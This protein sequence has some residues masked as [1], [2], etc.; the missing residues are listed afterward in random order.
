MFKYILER[1]GDINWMAISALVTF[2]VLFVIASVVILRRNP[3]YIRKMANMP[4]ED[5]TGNP[6]ANHETAYRHEK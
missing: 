6:I 5:G 1:A 4:L 2:F 3:D